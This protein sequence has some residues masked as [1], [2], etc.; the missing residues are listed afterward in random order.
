MPS[1]KYGVQEPSNSLQL[2]LTWF[3]MCGEQIASRADNPS[4]RFSKESINPAFPPHAGVVSSLRNSCW[5]VFIFRSGKSLVLPAIQRAWSRK[6]ETYSRPHDDS[7][8]SFRFIVRC[9]CSD[10][11]TPFSVTKW[12]HCQLPND[13]F[14]FEIFLSPLRRLCWLWCLLMSQSNF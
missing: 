2:Q 14:P 8:V 4:S 12:P 11:M 6:L 9:G 1:C 3:R 13:S 5:L 7:L 10:Q